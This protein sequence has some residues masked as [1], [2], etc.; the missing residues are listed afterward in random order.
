MEETLFTDAERAIFDELHI[1]YENDTLER[2]IAYKVMQAKDRQFSDYL[3]EKKANLVNIYGTTVG[4]MDALIDD[5]ISE[6][7]SFSEGT[8]MTYQDKAKQFLLGK[9]TKMEQT[10]LAKY[11]ALGLNEE[12]GEVAGKIKKAIRDDDGKIDT[13]RA[14]AI[15]LELGDVLWYLAILANTLGF[16]LDSIAAMN[17]QKL[18]LRKERGVIKGE[19]DNR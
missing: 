10:E 11:C 16:S 2:S 9:F 14:H 17:I 5:I 6:G 4:Q 8:K 7:I 1:H 3:K 15:A 12:A 18:T 19:G 13:E